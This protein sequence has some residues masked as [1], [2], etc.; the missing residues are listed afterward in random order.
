LEDTCQDEREKRF[1]GNLVDCQRLALLGRLS[2]NLTH[3]INNHLTGVSGYAQLLLGQERA[4]ELAKE[5]SKI[6]ASANEC[7]RL[8]SSFKR[9]ARFSSQ[10]K[11]YNSLNAIVQ[12]VLELFRRQLAKRNVEVVEEYSPEMPI[13]EIDAVALEQVFLNIIQNSFE[14]LQESGSRLRVATNTENGYLVVTLED[15]GPGFSQ[16]ALSHLFVP[17]FSTK[18]RL[19]CAGLGLAVAKML[20]ED[21]GGNIG[22]EALPNSGTRVRVSV[23]LEASAREGKE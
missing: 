10:E 14:A 20:L 7:K 13:I 2:S 17:F 21:Q 4:Q 12:Q 16:E 15:D 6:N 11:E 18:Q 8:I 19:H 23:P 3:E 9:F 5:L 1:H 22:V